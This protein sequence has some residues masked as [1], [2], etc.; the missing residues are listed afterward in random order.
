MI[1]APSSPP[2]KP[3]IAPRKLPIATAASTTTTA[4]GIE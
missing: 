1:A 2:K 4:I 3:A